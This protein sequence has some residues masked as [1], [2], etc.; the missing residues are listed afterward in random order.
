MIICIN[1]TIHIHIYM[2]L[3]LVQINNKY[4]NPD[5]EW[6]PGW[7]IFHAIEKPLIFVFS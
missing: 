7:W 4:I 3:L 5:G 1:D 6:T 2:L